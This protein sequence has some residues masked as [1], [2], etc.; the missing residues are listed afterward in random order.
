M[1]SAP[2]NV[3]QLKVSSV[4]IVK[5]TGLYIYRLLAGLLPISTIAPLQR[6]PNA[7]ARLLMNLGPC[8]LVTPAPSDT[9]TG[10]RFSTAFT[11]PAVH[12]MHSNYTR[13]SSLDLAYLIQGTIVNQ[14]WTG[15][16]S[17]DYG[18]QRRSHSALGK[19]AFSFAGPLAWNKL[20][21]AALCDIT[22]RLQFRKCKQLIYLAICLP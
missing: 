4:K 17:G 11:V 9:T 21:P 19:H 8:D 12:M 1:L 7:A 2:K 22:N 16:R 18:I 3:S 6:V 15:L 10:S 20:P 14:R 13:R 5:T